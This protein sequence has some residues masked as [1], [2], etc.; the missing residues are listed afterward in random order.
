MKS[1]VSRLLAAFGVDS[2]V[3]LAVTA[4]ANGA[5]DRS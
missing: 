3:L 5:V 1:Y 4:L 2:R